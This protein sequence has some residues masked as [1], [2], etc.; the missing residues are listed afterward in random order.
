MFSGVQP[1]V[2]GAMR[3]AR[4][5]EHVGEEN[6]LWDTVAAIE[7]LDGEENRWEMEQA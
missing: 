1:R 3:Q 7:K 5:V 4:F 2:M 6:F